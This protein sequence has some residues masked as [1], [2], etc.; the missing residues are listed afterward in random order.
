MLEQAIIEC[1][2]CGTPRLRYTE[3]GK[4]N[5][6][7][8]CRA[9]S[10]REWSHSNPDKKHAQDKQYRI[11]NP[12]KYRNSIIN[13]EAKKPEKY[14]ELKRQY[15]I[16]NRKILNE[17]FYIRVKNN[18]DMYRAIRIRRLARKANA[19]GTWTK[20]DWQLILDKY[21]NSC[22]DCGITQEEYGVRRLDVGHLIP[23]SRGGSNWPH[24]LAPQCRSCNSKQGSNIHPSVQQNARN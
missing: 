8:P 1:R 18:P 13:A 11:D 3:T 19:E 5:K 15:G 9:K 4:Q 7:K 24:N 17:K 10:M 12:E 14:K 6:C 2:V 16:K 20:E 22:I 21:N 23:L